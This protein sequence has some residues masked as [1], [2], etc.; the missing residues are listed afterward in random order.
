MLKGAEVPVWLSKYNENSRSLPLNFNEKQSTSNS[1][2]YQIVFDQ[3]KDIPIPVTV[4]KSASK[5]N[6]KI[7][8]R[9]GVSLFDMEAGVFV[10]KTWHSPKLIPVISN[11]DEQDIPYNENSDKE[12]T[13]LVGN[14][15][16]M[17]LRNQFVYFHTDSQSP[18]LVS[19][20][21]FNFQ[22]NY[23]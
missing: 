14:R 23:C 3:I 20:I 18:H 10:G 12:R 11:F 15:L 2:V 16:V 13:N 8:C 6:S 9:L 1:K 22:G 19:I 7:G 21:E 17:Q 4:L 5:T